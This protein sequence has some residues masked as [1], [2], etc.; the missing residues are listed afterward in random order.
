MEK[1]TEF[2]MKLSGTEFDEGF[3]LYHLSKTLSNISSLID[4]SYLTIEDKQKMTDKDRDILQVKTYNVR[5]GSFEADFV[6]QL[7]TVS[8]S[9]LP[10]VSSLTP[11]EVWKLLRDSYSYLNTVLQGNSKGENYTL[12]VADS[13]NVFNVINNTGSIV[14]QVHPDVLRNVER[15]EGNF[16]QMARLINPEKGVESISVFEK[17]SK[18]QHFF[19][20][21]EEKMNFE[22]RKRLE[23]ESITFLGKILTIDGVGF[24]GKLQVTSDIEG[25]KSGEYRYE[26]L[27]K[28]DTEM[29]RSAFMEVK[30][31]VALRETILN[32]STLTQ[33]VNK[34][35]IIKVK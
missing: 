1:S 28:D 27:T 10:M 22:S 25:L 24:N 29:L 18:K 9:L 33:R 35:R 12:E 7:G 14:L 21:R 17:V 15:A 26:F 8:A 34:L 30:E 20:G 11:D 16:E 23:S 31:I 32:T 3:N 2:T 19:M 6:I 13:N 5:T 4:K